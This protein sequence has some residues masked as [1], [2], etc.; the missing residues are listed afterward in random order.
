MSACLHLCLPAHVLVCMIVSATSLGRMVDAIKRLTGKLVVLAQG[1]TDQLDTDIARLQTPLPSV[2]PMTSMPPVTDI[3]CLGATDPDALAVVAALAPSNVPTVVTKVRIPCP[4][5]DDGAL[6]AS[7]W[8]RIKYLLTSFHSLSP[9]HCS[10]G[11]TP[12]SVP[13]P[14]CV[15]SPDSP[16]AQHESGWYCGCR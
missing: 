6:C 1:E 9:A 15:P 12:R 5:L 16:P 3:V 11:L 2:P 4:A 10:C 14:A 13:A 8:W 7:M